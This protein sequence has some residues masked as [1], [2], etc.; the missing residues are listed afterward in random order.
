M[1]SGGDAKTS[2]YAF[3]L[4]TLG[5]TGQLIGEGLNKTQIQQAINS[6]DYNIGDILIYYSED[7]GDSNGL[8]GHTQIYVG[9]K[10]P[11]GWSSDVRDNYG[12]SFVYNSKPSNCYTLYLYRVP[13][14]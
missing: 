14:F 8:S 9:S 7:S 2:G 6:I 10:S 4:K 5:W 3:Q 1:P 12:F 13:N 11:S